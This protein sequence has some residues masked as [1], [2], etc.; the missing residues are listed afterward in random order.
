MLTIVQKYIKIYQ[1]YKQYTYT[2]YIKNIQCI[3]KIRTYL[4]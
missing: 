3:K 4:Y 2:K 1:K